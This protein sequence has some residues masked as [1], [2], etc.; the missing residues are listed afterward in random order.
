MD[1]LQVGASPGL[2]AAA[3]RTGAELGCM[4]GRAGFVSSLHAILDQLRD[5][6]QSA[7]SEAGRRELPE[8]KQ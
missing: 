4:L 2:V 5:R 7:I 6:V 8:G 1:P 3:A